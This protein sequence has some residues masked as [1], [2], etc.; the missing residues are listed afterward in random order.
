MDHD[1]ELGVKALH[2]FHGHYTDIPGWFW[3]DLL[4][5]DRV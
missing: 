5:S 4:G 3:V 1:V 2:S